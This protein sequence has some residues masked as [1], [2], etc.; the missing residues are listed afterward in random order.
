MKDVQDITANLNRIA[1]S[2]EI[3]ATIGNLKEATAK[4]NTV[5]AKI[6]R[7]EGTVGK[8]VNDETVYNDLKDTVANAKE[9]SAD[10]KGL[11]TVIANAE[12]ITAK[13]KDD[14]Y[15]EQLDQGLLAFRK[16]CE[17]LD[18]GDGLKADVAEITGKASEL[19]DTLNIVA[20]RL[21]KGEG[22]L[23]KLAADETLYNEVN[24]LIRDMRT[25]IDNYR[26]TTPIT[27]FGSLATG[28][29]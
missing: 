28:A 19:V 7:G 15:F 10:L 11:K 27:T 2:G 23:G 8:L 12:E 1:S 25:V 4:V 9:V 21:E 20:T 5:M 17:S 26:D 18:F 29:L 6:E 14:K 13:L 24:G 3:E 16:A 22:T